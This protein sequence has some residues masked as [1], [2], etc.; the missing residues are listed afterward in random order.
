MRKLKLTCLLVALAVVT[1][2]CAGFTAPAPENEAGSQSA[3]VASHARVDAECLDSSGLGG[4]TAIVPTDDGRRVTLNWSYEVPHRSARLTASVRTRTVDGVPTYELAL[5]TAGNASDCRGRVKY[6][7]VLALP[8]TGDSY[9]VVVTLDGDVVGQL[10]NGE[11]SGG[12]GR[13]ANASV[14]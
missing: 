8:A 1:G 5:R 13:S 11:R 10:S 2:G 6:E 12:G 9:H 4:E 3:S 7:T 14:E